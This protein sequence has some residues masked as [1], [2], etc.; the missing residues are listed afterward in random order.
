MQGHSN[1][2]LESLKVVGAGKRRVICI[3]CGSSDRD[4]LVALFLAQSNIPQNKTET[5]QLLHIAP[6]FAL[7]NWIKKN[8][9]LRSTQADNREKGYALSYSKKVEKADIQHLLYP[10]DSFDWIICNHVLE[11]VDDD[12]KAMKELFRVLK[13]NG[14]G[15]LQVPIALGLEKTIEAK[16]HWNEIDCDRELGQWDHKRL[17]GMDYL[18]RLSSVGFKVQLWSPSNESICNEHNLNATEFIIHVTK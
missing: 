2:K 15:V 1:A 6:E 3:S 14:Q 8:T 9:T 4:R 7:S 13:P 17:Y 12:L 18:D 10:S 11:H 16:P 5:P